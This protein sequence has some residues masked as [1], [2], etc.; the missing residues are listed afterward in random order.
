MTSLRLWLVGLAG[1]ITCL[2]SAAQDG[3]SHDTGGTCRFLPCKSWRKAW[4]DHGR[5]RCTS[6]Q[7]SVGGFCS[8]LAASVLRSRA[9]ATA[10][11]T[12]TTTTTTCGH[13]TQPSI[14]GCIPVC[15]HHMP[16]NGEAECT[17]GYDLE[18]CNTQ[19]AGAITAEACRVKCAQGFVG[20]PKAACFQ[21]GGRFIFSGCVRPKCS[22][23]QSSASA[24]DLHLCNTTSRKI[25]E[26]EC[27]VTCSQN[28]TAVS[29]P[30]ASCVADGG[31]FQFSGCHPRCVA[32]YKALAPGY[33]LEG[34]DS[35]SG[36]I[37]ASSCQ[38]AC[39]PGYNT[40]FSRYGT[41]RAAC[42]AAGAL[43][44]LSGC[45]YNQCEARATV[46]Y[47]LTAC[48]STSKL[49]SAMRPLLEAP[50]CNV[51]CAEGYIGHPSAHCQSNFAYFEFSGCEP[52]DLI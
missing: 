8:A 50:D 26:P 18:H 24:Y 48:G 45:D 12:T 1:T 17:V 52:N 11:R 2:T 30:T 10:L 38:V 16:C 21:A 35:R 19:V 23:H 5:C 27:T 9:P 28:S 40:Y 33:S 42:S 22:A 37:L 15:S 4:C 43:F 46:G 3:C 29:Q 20:T 36:P 47:N 34:C 44:N 32:P 49:S 51:S 6:G 31:S 25:S 41:A 14:A 7:C 13:G 39:A